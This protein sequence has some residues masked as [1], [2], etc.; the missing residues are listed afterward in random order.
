MGGAPFAFLTHD[1]EGEKIMLNNFVIQFC[2]NNYLSNKFIKICSIVI[3]LSQKSPKQ[4]ITG[5]KTWVARGHIWIIYV[6]LSWGK[7]KS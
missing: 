4:Q 3:E 5:S 7:K 6:K 2:I 1:H